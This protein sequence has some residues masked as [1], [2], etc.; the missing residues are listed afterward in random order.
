MFL[1]G[2]RSDDWMVLLV[3]FVFITVAPGTEIALGALGTT[4][5]IWRM[6]ILLQFGVGLCATALLVFVFPTGRFVPTW[7]R[8]AFILF[9]ALVVAYGGANIVQ[10]GLSDP[11]PEWILCYSLGFIAQISRHRRATSAIQR[12]QFRWIVFGFFIYAPTFVLF[13]LLSTLVIPT[14]PEVQRILFEI[15]GTVFLFY[16]PALL[17]FVTAVFATLHYRLWDIDLL[18]NRTLVYVP[19]TA[20]LAGLFAASITL[21]QR[22]FVALT[23]QSS[24]AATALTTLV[25]VAAFDPLKTGLQH[26]VDRRF[27][28][29]HDS[30]K[31]ID[32]F[33]EEVQAVVEVLDAEQLSRRFLEKAVR[34]LNATGGTVYVQRNGGAPLVQHAGVRDGEV[35]LRVPLQH[36]GMEVGRLELGARKNGQD[37]ADAERDSLQMNAERIARALAVIQGLSG[38]S[39]DF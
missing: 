29:A 2:I 4:Q 21:S 1:F 28:E 25:V 5:P 33:G 31:E 14:R 30:V 20:I 35:R 17:L 8:P 39:L 7:T 12:Q 18:I 27:K 3:S 34:A 13:S 23:G 38:K 11:A 6:P 36:E 26:L 16:V 15:W 9:A 19:L 24:D 32:Q 37:Y 22:F 10:H